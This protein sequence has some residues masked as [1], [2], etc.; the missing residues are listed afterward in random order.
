MDDATQT[1]TQTPTKTAP[2]PLSVAFKS[3]QTIRK[4]VGVHYI[5]KE[6]DIDL[7]LMAMLSRQHGA[8][9]GAP[10]EAKSDLLD[11]LTR[12][13]DG[14]NLFKMLVM[15]TSKPEEMFGLFD[16]AELRQGRYVHLSAG[17]LPEAHFAFFDEGFK[18]G[19]HF[20]NAQLMALNERQWR[21]G[22]KLCTM[23]LE[24]AFVASNEMP[25]D[26]EEGTAA[27]LDRFL[28]KKWVTTLSDAGHRQLVDAALAWRQQRAQG[29]N[30]SANGT[31]L[32]LEQ[33]NLL[34]QAT[35]A[36]VIPQAVKDAWFD[37]RAQIESAGYGKPSSR[38]SVWLWDAVCAHALLH[39]RRT[40]SIDDLAVLQYVLWQREADIKPLSAMVLKVANPMIV[41]ARE[42]ADKMP[43][44]IQ[45]CMQEFKAAGENMVQKTAAVTRARQALGD[46]AEKLQ[47][48]YLKAKG[49]GRDLTEIARLGQECEANIKKVTALLGSPRSFTFE[50]T[51]NPA[52][53]VTL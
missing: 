53:D 19:S 28:F 40:A 51:G 22:S 14:A 52:E 8:F 15:K 38:R 7:I 4:E 17:M 24:C 3:L 10:G 48:E 50:D 36:V 1:Q 39:G 5:E 21:N 30:P 27:Y 11:A 44:I 37:L 34:Q 43:A 33:L 46:I 31:M 35:L 2:S 47:E 25:A 16:P 12:R 23:P 29:Q 41:V 32:T 6:Q 13:I 18:G 20:R 9:I 42:H 49:T 45:T 26:D